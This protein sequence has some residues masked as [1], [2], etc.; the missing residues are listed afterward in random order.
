MEAVVEA[1]LHPFARPLSRLGDCFDLGRADAGGLFDQDVSAGV[2]RRDREIGEPIMGGRDDDD[3]RL[4]PKCLAQRAG[5]LAGVIGGERP[6]G[7]W[8]SVVA[9]DEH[10]RAKRLRPLA[11]DQPAADDRDS[12]G[13]AH[14]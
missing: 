14:R 1:D 4:G 13:P 7:L 6:R 5:G 3:V 2:E 10:V 11:A 12:Q 8:H 9:S